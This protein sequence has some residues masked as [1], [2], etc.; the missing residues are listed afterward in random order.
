[1]KPFMARTFH[2][3]IWLDKW[4]VNNL[5]NQTSFFITVYWFM[6]HNFRYNLIFFLITYV[7]PMVYM[8]SC[9]VK[10]GKSCSLSLYLFSSHIVIKN[11]KFQEKTCGEII[12]EKSQTVRSSVG[13]TRGRLSRCL[14]WSSVCSGSAGSPTT[15]TSSIPTTTQISWGSPT[16]RIST[17]ASIG[18]PWPTVRSIQLWAHFSLQA[19]DKIL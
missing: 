5:S 3:R 8:A 16:S 7:T 13:K 9:Y 6:L 1:M 12:P 17:S 18:S 10:M 2:T 15:S 4:I 11:N 14:W 19:W